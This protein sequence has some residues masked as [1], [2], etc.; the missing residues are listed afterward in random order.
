VQGVGEA[1]VLVA[2]EIFDVKENVYDDVLC[3]DSTSAESIERYTGRG[4]PSAFAKF[5]FGGEILLFG[6][7]GGGFIGF[8]DGE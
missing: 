8:N 4:L 2:E 6:G 3:G 7:E 1:V 5:I